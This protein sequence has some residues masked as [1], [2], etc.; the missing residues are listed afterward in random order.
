MFGK[1]GTSRLIFFYK[2]VKMQMYEDDF[3]FAGM[4]ILRMYMLSKSINLRNAHFAGI[5]I[6]CSPEE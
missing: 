3:T 5:L 2:S 4:H 6:V 1:Y